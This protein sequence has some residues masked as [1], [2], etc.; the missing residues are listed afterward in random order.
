V[1]NLTTASSAS[2][3]RREEIPDIRSSETT[4]PVALSGAAASGELRAQR[5]IRRT[6]FDDPRILEQ[7][8]QVKALFGWELGG[9]TDEPPQ[10][11]DA[12]SPPLIASSIPRTCR[13]SVRQ[14][15][16]RKSAGAER[17]AM[18]RTLSKSFQ[19][20]DAAHE[21]SYCGRRSHRSR[22]GRRTVEP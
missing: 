1:L 8:G 22:R 3:P 15:G 17:A 10:K 12:A 13:T 19:G 4:S 14:D 20:L 9:I 2:S 21:L 5:L 16:R 6:V 11:E 7:L 18:A